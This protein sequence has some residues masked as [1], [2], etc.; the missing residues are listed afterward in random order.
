M[1]GFQEFVSRVRESS[2]KAKDA[3][4]AEAVAHARKVG[5]LAEEAAASLYASVK[6]AFSKK[7]R[8]VLNVPPEDV[9]SFLSGGKLNQTYSERRAQ[10]ERAVG[11]FGL[12]P[13]FA[14]LTDK[15]EGNRSVAACSMILEGVS[16]R[17]VLVNGDAGRL[18]NPSRQDYKADPA[19]VLYSFEH[20]DDCRAAAAILALGPHELA[21]GPPQAVAEVLDDDKDYGVC[22]VLLFG[23]LSPSNVSKVVVPDEEALG[24]VRACLDKANRLVPV[25][26]SSR[27]V[28]VRNPGLERERFEPDAPFAQSP[29]MLHFA[30]GDRVACKP[31]ASAPVALGTVLDMSD[32]RVVVQWDTMDRT[33]FDLVEALARLMDAPRMPQPKAGEVVYSLPGMGADTIAL[34]ASL[35]VDPVNLYA[36]ASTR[37]PARE[38]EGMD[39]DFAKAMAAI[40]VPGKVVRGFAPAG[41]DSVLAF[42]PRKWFEARLPYGNR[43]VV[44][45]TTKGPRIEAG[46]APDYLLRPQYTDVPL[47]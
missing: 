18:R 32:G 38:G 20:K 35:G 24:C 37:V 13:I 9:S 47:E 30:V 2:A 17:V 15:L 5:G 43:L 36:V 34:L 31:M 16:D 26:S 44:D 25:E 11:C 27:R 12:S 28:K 3:G 42:V 23:G 22:H 8:I 40:D 45:L 41:D 19:E 4:R 10:V 21:G 29:A 1:P 39:E 33:V 14:L 7:T 6:E 46:E